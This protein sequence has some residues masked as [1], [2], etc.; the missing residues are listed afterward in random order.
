MNGERG[1]VPSFPANLTSQW[2]GTLYTAAVSLGLTFALG[3]VLRPEGFGSYSYILTLAT[4]FFILQE[5]GF[6][7]L[8][9]REKTLSTP[10]MAGLRNRLFS[11]ALGHTVMVTLAGAFFVLVLPVKYRAGVFTAFLCFG[12]QAWANF[13]SAELRAKGFFPREA[14]WQATVR[15][16]GAVGILLA[17]FLVRPE[18]WAVFSGW[19]AGLFVSLFLS[20]KPITRPAFR[21]FGFKDIR[22]ACFGFMAIDAAT[23][24]Y[25]RSDI[26]LLAHLTRNSAEVGYYAA[27]YRFLDGIVL[28]AAP[29]GLIWFRKLRLMWEEKR[30]FGSQLFR[31]TLVMLGAAGLVLLGGILFGKEIVLLTFG[32]GYGASATVL[33]WL[34]GATIFVLPNGVLTQAAIAQ[35]IEHLYAVA[36][37]VAALVNIGLNFL[38]IP[39]FGGLGAAWATI[40]T[41]AFLTGFLI[42]GLKRYV[43]EP[44]LGH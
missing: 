29:L 4:L 11:W 37:G 32:Q 24:I 25:Y 13:I 9:F 38:L 23:T 42:F 33:P 17:L 14:V 28:L 5:G 21:G 6:K 15:S 12:L 35:N 30:L 18:P 43:M 31:M 44:E 36:A 20:P 27:A 2:L 8:L 41:E 26:I 19:G 1:D 7:T 34:L 16:L 39:R 3:R 40:V 22:R 10:T